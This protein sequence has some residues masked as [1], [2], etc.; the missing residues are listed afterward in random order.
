MHASHYPVSPDEAESTSFT[1]ESIDPHTLALSFSRDMWHGSAVFSPSYI[2]SDF[3]T[4]YFPANFY[5][6]SSTSVSRANSGILLQLERLVNGQWVRVQGQRLVAANVTWQL[7]A[8]GTYRVRMIQ[9][10]NPILVVPVTG[11]FL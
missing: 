7:P 10:R 8:M 2:A 6:G 11:R 4:L 3:I 5:A 9:S 1:L